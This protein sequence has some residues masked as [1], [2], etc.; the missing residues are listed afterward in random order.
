MRN[1]F[2]FNENFLFDNDKIVL[3]SDMAG[4]G[5]TT[6][7]RKIYEIFLDDKEQL[8]FI[9]FIPKKMTKN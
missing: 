3:I 7:L 5:K 4:S 6:I 1:L 9:I 8:N 2:T